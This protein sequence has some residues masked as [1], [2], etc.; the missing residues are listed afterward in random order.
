MVTGMLWFDDSKISLKD[1]VVKAVDYYQKKY[2][3]KPNLV[4]IHPKILE[5]EKVEVEGLTVRA[6]RIVLPGHLW[7]G[8]E[9]KDNL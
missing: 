6:N 9:D 3:K 5:G 4:L 7:I 2:L 1:K 8:M